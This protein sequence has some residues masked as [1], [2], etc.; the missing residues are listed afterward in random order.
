[1]LTE[2]VTIRL[3]EE[4]REELD[5]LAR[6]NRLKVSEY[7]R[8]VLFSGKLD[9][10]TTLPKD[11]VVKLYVLMSE[12]EKVRIA[13]PKINIDGIERVAHELWQF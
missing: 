6:M 9:V 5:N 3:E 13:N 2:K 11:F 12:L 4:E 10:K 1:M 7:I 8:R